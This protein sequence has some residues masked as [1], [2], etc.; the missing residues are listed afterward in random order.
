MS[1]VFQVPDDGAKWKVKEDSLTLNHKCDLHSGA[2]GKLIIS[3]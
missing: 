1:L 2:R 3:H